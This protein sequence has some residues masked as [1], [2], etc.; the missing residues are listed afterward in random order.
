MAFSFKT[1]FYQ[2]KCQLLIG[3]TN[4]QLPSTSLTISPIMLNLLQPHL[5]SYH[6]PNTSLSLCT[7]SSLPLKMFFLQTSDSNS[8]ITFRSC[9]PYQPPSYSFL[10][11][12][13]P[14]PL[15]SCLPLQFYLVT[16]FFTPN[17]TLTLNMIYLCTY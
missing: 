8:L 6:S 12:L 16:L 11:Q 13:F 2:S 4:I 1:Q 14:T 9:L 17:K 15:T 3:P 10:R 7:C 5:L